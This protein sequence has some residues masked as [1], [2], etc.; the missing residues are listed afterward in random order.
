MEKQ[1][2]IGLLPSGYGKT[3]CA[4]LPTILSNVENPVT[5]VISPLR[6]PMDDQI[7]NFHKWNFTAAK[8]EPD[9]DQEIVSVIKDGA[10]NFVFSSS[11]TALKP[12]WKG[13]FMSKVWKKNIIALVVDEVH[14]IS[15]WGEDF[16]NELRH[17]HELRSAIRNPVLALT[18]TSTEAVKQDIK[19]YLQI[20]DAIV[21]YRSP[22]RPNIFIDFTKAESTDLEGN[23]YWLLSHLR[24]KNSAAKKIIVHCRSADK[25][26]EVYI[27][28]R[29]NLGLDAYVDGIKDSSHAL[30][31]MFHRS[32]HDES[33]T[34]IPRNFKVWGIQI[35]DVDIVMHLGSP[36]YILSYWQEMGRCARDR[37]PGYS[38]VLYDNFTLSCKGTQKNVKSIV[39]GDTCFRKTVLST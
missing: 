4:V 15:E 30:V 38:Y 6:A 8:I 39:N 34:R 1:N 14:C 10:Y 26:A 27:L 2:V 22:D 36:K 33:K 37:R 19:K 12:L 9:M 7:Q 21:I 11:E 28:L 32:I 17:L 16:R 18:A 3:F 13:V 20:D 35:D 5:L 31:E 29:R 25:V 24:E 23:F